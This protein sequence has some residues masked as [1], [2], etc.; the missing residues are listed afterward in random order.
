MMKSQPP[1]SISAT[2]LL[3]QFFLKAIIQSISVLFFQHPRAWAFSS[4]IAN[5]HTL[6][7]PFNNKA[8]NGIS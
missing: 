7:N 1:T 2:S 8:R 3:N 5:T 4:V 6:Y